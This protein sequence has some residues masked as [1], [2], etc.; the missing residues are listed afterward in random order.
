[1]LCIRPHGLL[2][3]LVDYMPNKNKKMAAPEKSLWDKAMGNIL[4][5]FMVAMFVTY[6]ILGIL[7]SESLTYLN[8]LTLTHLVKPSLIVPI[9]AITAWGWM[10]NA[11]GIGLILVIWFWAIGNLRLTKKGHMLIDKLKKGLS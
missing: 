6:F 2:H 11:L 4:F 8:T 10:Q 3:N 7:E 9:W 1:M 5:R